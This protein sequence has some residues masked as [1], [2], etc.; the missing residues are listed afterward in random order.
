MGVRLPSVQR[1]ETKEKKQHLNR[2]EVA[3]CTRMPGASNSHN[4]IQVELIA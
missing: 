2:V 4:N 1:K 3:A